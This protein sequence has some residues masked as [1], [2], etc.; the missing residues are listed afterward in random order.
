DF[1]VDVEAARRPS[2]LVGE[3]PAQQALL[4]GGLVAR[5][6]L[7]ERRKGLDGLFLRG[8][9]LERAGGDEGLIMGAERDG[10]WRQHGP[11]YGPSTA[12]IASREL[13]QG[14]VCGRGR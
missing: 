14:G 10:R 5:K 8:V 7:L 1:A 3:Q 6:P 12:K 11:L 4:A 2:V 9:G 13:V